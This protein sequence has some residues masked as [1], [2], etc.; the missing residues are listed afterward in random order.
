M[1]LIH[2]FDSHRKLSKNPLQISSTTYVYHLLK[3]KKTTHKVDFV[4]LPPITYREDDVVASL[5]KR[6]TLIMGS[7]LLC[8]WKKTIHITIIQV[9]KFKS[10]NFVFSRLLWSH[11]LDLVEY[12]YPYLD[13]DRETSKWV[14]A[15]FESSSRPHQIL[16][17]VETDDKV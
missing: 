15:A 16:G 11:H 6:S 8:N 10:R 12:H 2:F 17:G 13:M 9:Y 5:D 4:I 14:V 7:L 3:N 1:L